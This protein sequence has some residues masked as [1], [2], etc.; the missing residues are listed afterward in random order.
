MKKNSAFSLMEVSIVVLIVGIIIAGTLQSSALVRK[1]RL[2]TAKS[3]TRSAPVPG[4]KDLVLWYETTLETS[5][6]DS[7][8]FSDGGYLT[9]W[10]DNSPQSPNKNNATQ[11]TQANQPKYYFTSFDGAIPSARLDGNDSMAFDGSRLI[12]NP[13]T[14]FV[15]EQRRSGAATSYFITGSGSADNQVLTLGYLT[16]TQLVQSHYG[17]EL[18]Y[19]TLS[20]YSSPMPR[21]LTYMADSTNGKQAWINGG[22]AYS[23]AA[24]TGLLTSF[25]G[26]MIG[27]TYVGDLGEVIIFSRDLET[28]ER[29]AVEKYLSKK[30]KVKVT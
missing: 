23:D 15:V 7:E 2:N 22:N 11:A 3:L 26:A 14:I 13:Y 10:Y 28:Y 20:A 12:G 29:Q 8:Q 18:D 1:M 25:T 19:G 24:Q 17:T 16:A 30:F 9:T 21:I 5:F 6:N 27:N 4:I